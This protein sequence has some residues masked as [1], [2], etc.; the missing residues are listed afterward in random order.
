MLQICRYACVRKETSRAGSV[1]ILRYFQDYSPAEIAKVIRS[2][3]RTVDEWL[4][5]SRREAKLYLDDPLQL[6]F[7]QNATAGVLTIDNL[8]T[9]LAESVVDLMHKTRAAIYRS[10]QGECL[11]DVEL[12]ALYVATGETPGQQLDCETLGHIASCPFCLDR[13]NQ[14]LGLSPLSVRHA[15]QKGMT[16]S[17]QSDD[18]GPTGS[19]AGGRGTGRQGGGST[20]AFL[21][22]GRAH[23]QRVIEHRPEELLLSINGLYLSSVKIDSELSEVQLSL[24]DQTPIEF[25]EIYSERGVRL[26]FLEVARSYSSR[27][28][29]QAFVSLSDGRTL[30]LD[31]KHTIPYP[32]LRVAYA[33]PLWQEAE[34][35]ERSL[36]GLS[37]P[38]STQLSPATDPGEPA[39]APGWLTRLSRRLSAFRFPQRAEAPSR[40]QAL[41]L[42]PPAGGDETET[43]VVFPPV[44]HSYDSSGRPE[45]PRLFKA[46]LF[47]AL[48][49][50]PFWLRLSVASAG[51]AA[52]L[53]AALVLINPRG[54]TVKAT[55][56]L[57]RAQLEEE[58][59][60][61]QPGQAV[62]RVLNLEERTTDGRVVS[63]RQ[64]QVWQDGKNGIKT[65]RLYDEQHQLIAGEWIKNQ[66]MAGT[67]NDSRTVYRRGRSPQTDAANRAQEVWQVELSAQGFSTLVGRTEDASLV[68]QPD[69]YVLSYQQS[70][71]QPTQLSGIRV[72]KASLT[73]RRADLHAIEQTLLVSMSDDQTPSET[74]SPQ[75]REFRLLEGSFER[76]PIEKVPPDSFK[77]DP[78]LLG[79]N[80]VS[81]LSP[82]IDTA[83][84]AGTPLPTDRPAL[85]VAELAALQVEI[86]H[87]LDRAGANLGEQVNVIPTANGSLKIEAMVDT[88]Q[89][90]AE[91][92]RALRPLAS[93]PAVKISVQ[94]FAEAQIHQKEEAPK[95]TEV[96][97][98]EVT[99][100]QIPVYQDLRRHFTALN[101]P[102]AKEADLEA[103]INRFAEQIL[104]R[105]QQAMRHA[106]A[107]KRFSQRFTAEEIRALTPE[108]RSKWLAII[109]EHARQFARATEIIRGDLEPI[110]FANLT[111]QLEKEEKEQ[112]EPNSEI[113]A[114]TDDAS[115]LPALERMFELASAQNQVLQ[116]S[117]SLSSESATT[118]DVKAP[119]FWRSLKRA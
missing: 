73:L 30:E 53:I 104:D 70:D 50:A 84:P 19:A 98:V 14:L 34:F 96:E 110:F 47:G 23:V 9:N 17:D 46:G 16:D 27:M 2:A 39:G 88:N 18:D 1:L 115:L 111:R 97:N 83:H 7:M 78:E 43:P 117:F 66:G 72:L 67:T 86:F 56:L 109:N 37:E 90:K 15:T 44:P 51:A 31:F 112:T 52:L 106:W 36:E 63:R 94:T 75:L 74:R 69:V 22:R 58:T 118:A 71:P 13:V 48:I 10:R 26:L 65:R 107:L 92:L 91:I 81:S 3:R 102:P 45:K 24:R 108:A 114:L 11:T 64:I 60:V 8:E 80:A 29:R 57:R 28:E 6:K 21:N 79:V 35:D 119:Q 59:L 38:V 68:E 101:R 103:A 105:S 20:Q 95:R 113:G 12:Q 100:N 82:G 61:R 41:S 4:R 33:D 99:S 85:S 5:L 62:H 87:L 40:S 93:Q 54:T 89:R 42:E 32:S 55:E 25:I 49:H 116:S 76:R 77:P